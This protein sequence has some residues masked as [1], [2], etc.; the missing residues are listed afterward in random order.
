MLTSKPVRCP[1]PN[2]EDLLLLP[3]ETP[4]SGISAYCDHILTR[5][6]DLCWHL[7]A[8]RGLVGDK[9]KVDSSVRSHRGSDQRS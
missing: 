1:F 8:E 2:V 4:L 5:A 7:K 9:S 3:P 6:Y